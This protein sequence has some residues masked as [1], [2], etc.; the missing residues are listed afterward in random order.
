M[1]GGELPNGAELVYSPNGN[2]QTYER[3][4]VL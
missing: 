2:T 1:Y 3:L 4:Y